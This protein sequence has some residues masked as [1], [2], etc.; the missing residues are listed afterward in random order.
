MHAH[1]PAASP[2]A[3]PAS[4]ST[5][6]TTCPLHPPPTLLPQPRPARPSS[7]SLPA[8]N[9]R[10]GGPGLGRR[11]APA[12]PPAPLLKCPAT[13][14]ATLDAIPIDHRKRSF[15][16]L[17][18][19]LHRLLLSVPSQPDRLHDC[20]LLRF[21]HRTRSTASTPL[22]LTVLFTALTTTVSV[23]LVSLFASQGTPHAPKPPRAS[24]SPC[25]PARTCTSTSRPAN[26]SSLALPPRPTVARHDPHA[27]A[28]ALCSQ[29]RPFPRYAPMPCA[30]LATMHQ[31]S[32]TRHCMA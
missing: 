14:L 7:Y 8:Y 11:P 16:S 22:S 6:S 13:D 9:T 26:H 17:A 20:M 23:A 32:K 27:R 5:T 2:P 4:T 1:Q 21:H 15:S 30:P 18:S 28:S 24:L 3:S 25:P 10:R 12:P 31:A 19:F 29:E